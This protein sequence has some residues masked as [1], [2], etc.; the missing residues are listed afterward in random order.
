[1]H[2]HGEWARKSGREGW[3]SVWAQRSS[4]CRVYW[5]SLHARLDPCQNCS[6]PAAKRSV[7]HMWAQRSRSLSGLVKLYIFIDCTMNYYSHAVPVWQSATDQLLLSRFASWQLACTREVRVRYSSTN[8]YISLDCMYVAHGFS[9][10]IVK[11]RFWM[12]YACMHD[13]WINR[14][15][16]RSRIQD[17][18]QMHMRTHGKAKKTLRRSQSHQKIKADCIY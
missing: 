7:E 2:D 6:S 5:F 10:Q 17:W 3:S 11:S 12:H 18:Y 14:Q 13:I 8:S 9:L 1:M 15:S 4:Q 16:D